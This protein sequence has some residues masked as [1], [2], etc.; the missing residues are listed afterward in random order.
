MSMGKPDPTKTYKTAAFLRGVKR[1]DDSPSARKEPFSAHHMD[2]LA[3]LLD[4]KSPRHS[5]LWAAAALGFFFL[6]RVSNIAGQARGRYNA[7][8]VVL[9]ENVRFF[10]DGKRVALS[11]RSAG[12]I[13]Q[14]EIWVCKSKNDRSG[15]SR[16]LSRSGHPVL[17]PVLALVRH[18]LATEG[19]PEGWPV[20]AWGASETAS[21]EAA[22]L[23][24]RADLSAILKLAGAHLGEDSSRIGTHSLRIGGA[25]ALHHCGVPDRWIMWLGNWRSMVFLTYCR[26]GDE[27]P[28]HFAELL[29]AALAK[30][31]SESTAILGGKLAA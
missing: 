12:Q 18:L 24:T 7:S 4:L 22:Q 1:L 16:R 13:D 19:L 17:C 31:K 3:R 23:I 21:G 2:M 14:V 10:I 6:L 30:P 25:T 11:R 29:V 9:R 20:V 28:T 27:Y 26:T 15:F 5:A 8:Y